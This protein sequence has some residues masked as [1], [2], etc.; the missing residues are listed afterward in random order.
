MDIYGTDGN[1]TLEY[2]HGPGIHIWVNVWGGK[3]DD[4]IRVA[5][6]TA[7]GEA[8]NDTIVG[9]THDGAGFAPA[10]S[11]RNSPAGITANLATGIVQDGFG[12]VDTLA[13]IHA[14][15]DSSFNDHITGSGQDD[16][17]I[18]SRGSDTVV[19]GGGNDTVQFNLRSTDVTTTYDI[20]ARLFSVARQAPGDAGTTTLSGIGRVSFSGSNADNASIVVA[21][22]AD[23]GVRYTGGHGS[24]VVRSGKGNDTI[25]G[26]SGLDTVVFTGNREGYTVV[27]TA[28]GITVGGALGQDTLAQVERVVFGDKGIAFDTGG[29]AG[30]AFRLYQAAFDRAPDAFGLGFWISRL[31]LGV[32]LAT[33]AGGFTSSSEFTDMFGGQGTASVVAKLY[34]NILKRP[35]DTDGVAFWSGVLDRHEATIADVLAGFS[36]SPENIANTVGVMQNG[37]EYLPY[38]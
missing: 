15:H 38:L 21:G 36:E 6:V 30:Q 3:G 31:D 33:V 5:Q 13:G 27:K 20:G 14:I 25:D 18:L 34:A 17:F 35:G 7:I 28:A 29:V 37:L 12:T 10:A 32:S 11:Y 26:G 9:V 24:D 8:G 16:S 19:G 2:L 4:I 22:T 23:A 1:D